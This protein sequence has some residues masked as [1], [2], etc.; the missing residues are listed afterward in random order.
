MAVG[1]LRTGHLSTIR[2]GRADHP[3][4]VDHPRVARG[5][6]LAITV[7]IVIAVIGWGAAGVTS[8]MNVRERQASGRLAAQAGL[9]AVAGAGVEVVVSDASQAAKAGENPSMALVQDSDLIFLNMMLWYAGAR[10]V[11]INGER[12]TA[13]SAITSS[14]P[15]LV[16]NRRRIVGP[17]HVTAVGDPRVLKGVLET[18][19]GFI[20][21]MRQ[22]GLGV[23]VTTRQQVTIPGGDLSSI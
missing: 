14:G 5:T 21:R 15:V 3:D 17:F 11:A 7:W 13:Q 12:I 9:T 18:R 8:I 16:V 10:A 1:N 20:E 22:G 4:H 23:E 2:S 19:G 6:R